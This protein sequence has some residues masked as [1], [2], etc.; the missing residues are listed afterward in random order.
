MAMLAKH[1]AAGV[2]LNHPPASHFDYLCSIL[3][4]LDGT[5]VFPT[6][7]KDDFKFDSDPAPVH[8]ILLQ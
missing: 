5:E 2:S 8:S 3:F 4:Y 6:K 1:I 7:T